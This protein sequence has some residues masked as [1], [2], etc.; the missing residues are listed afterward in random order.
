MKIYAKGFW[1]IVLAQAVFLITW[2][3]WHEHVRTNA[4]GILLKTK[5]VDPRDL[6]RGDYMILGYE[7]AD[8]TL[9][10]SANGAREYWV[11]LEKRGEHHAAVRAS[12]EEPVREAGQ[13]AVRARRVGRSL[14]YGIE[15][16]YVPEGK[17]TPRFKTLEVEAAVS[18]A[19]NLYI[20]RLLLDGEP[21]P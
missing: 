6:L 5:P 15:H 7:I 12:V 16:Y 20:R 8:V 18:P 17:G 19:G 10:A 21:Y 1:L 14:L 3:G 4:P 9:P 13:I 11:V 2:A